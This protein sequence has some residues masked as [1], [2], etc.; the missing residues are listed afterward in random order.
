MKALTCR[1]EDALVLGGAIRILVLN[2]DQQRVRLG[3][4]APPAIEVTAGERTVLRPGRR[5]LVAWHSDPQ[6]LCRQIAARYPQADV[7]LRVLRSGVAY[8]GT[9]PCLLTRLEAYTLGHADATRCCAQHPPSASP[10][11]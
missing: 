5:D 3:I 11:R 2:H 7:D 10:G 8:F 6:Q 9:D 4:E 1:R